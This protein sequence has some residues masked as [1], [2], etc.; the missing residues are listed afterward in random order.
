MTFSPFESAWQI[1]KDVLTWFF[2]ASL[3]TDP[4]IQL[5]NNCVYYVFGWWFIGTLLFKPCYLFL[6]WLANM[7]RGK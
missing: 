5:L 4:F 1:I 6:K 7:F 2:P 3:L